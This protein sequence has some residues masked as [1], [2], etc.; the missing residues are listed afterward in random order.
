MEY[1]V[2]PPKNLPDLFTVLNVIFSCGQFVCIWIY[3]NYRQFT[4]KFEEVNF[5]EMNTKVKTD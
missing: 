3:L 5:D 1:L 2:T 4:I